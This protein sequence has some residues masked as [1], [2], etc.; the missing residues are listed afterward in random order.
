MLFPPEVKL[1]SLLQLLGTQ[2]A[3]LMPLASPLKPRGQVTALCSILTVT[4]QLL[5]SHWEKHPETTGGM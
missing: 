4:I 1:E 3:V 5:P 2:R